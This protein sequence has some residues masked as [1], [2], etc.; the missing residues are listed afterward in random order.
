M[1]RTNKIMPY[2]VPENYFDQLPQELTTSALIANGHLQEHQLD[3]T[4]QMPFTIDDQYFSGL[5]NQILSGIKKEEESAVQLH[6]TYGKTLPYVAPQGYFENLA[7]NVMSEINKGSEDLVDTAYLDDWKDNVYEVPAD[8]FAKADFATKAI[9]SQQKTKTKELYPTARKLTLNNWAAAAVM[10]VIFTIGG[11][12]MN[13]DVNNYDAASVAEKKLAE[14]SNSD[15]E[16]YISDN[17]D[18]F[19]LSLLE[20]EVSKLPQNSG[21]KNTQSLLNDISEEDIKAYLEEEGI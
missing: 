13:K 12:W 1:E 3:A 15:L 21:R 19:D 14:V 8:Y 20:K 6:S 17:I 16:K 10:L 2:E 7:E 5:E 18:E 4:R 11:I 9:A